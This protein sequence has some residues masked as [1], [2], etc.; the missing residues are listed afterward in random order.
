[1]EALSLP[2]FS[3]YNMRSIWS[4][5]NSLASDMDDRDTDISILSEVWEKKENVRHQAKIEELLLHT[6]SS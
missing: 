5:L 1:M 2:I 4:K 3:V 6:L